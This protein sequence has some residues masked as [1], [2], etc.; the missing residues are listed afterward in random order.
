MMLYG[1]K[2][3]G[4]PDLAGE[5]SIK[6]FGEIMDLDVQDF[7]AFPVGNI[8][9]DRPQPIKLCFMSLESRNLVLGSA[10]KLPKGISVEK[11]LPRR[12][13]AKSREFRRYG[14]E[15]KQIDQTLITRTIIKGPKLV[16]EMKQKDVDELKYD[17]TIV[18][19]YIPEPVSPTEKENV[20]SREGLLPSKTLEMVGKNFIFFSD[21]CPKEN[22]E[23]TVKYFSETYLSN[24]D[25]EKVVDIDAE[26]VMAKR[27]IRVKMSERQS[28]H[29]FKTKYEKF[30]FNSKSPKISVFLG[31]E[32]NN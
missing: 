25:K 30:P 31:K 28:C 8:S 19:E 24:E 21:L 23:A 16:L 26:N 6:V 2:Q 27:Y 20:K 18:K 5:I 3:D 29:D 17:W 9:G 22:K 32:A 4:G 12:Y 7:K 11:C 13:R 10:F 15:L 14:W 1:Y